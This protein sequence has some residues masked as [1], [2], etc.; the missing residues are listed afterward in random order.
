MSTELPVHRIYTSPGHLLSY[1]MAS[2]G[3]S[4]WSHV[5]NS[6]CPSL[7]IGMH[8]DCWS[9]LVMG[10]HMWHRLNPLSLLKLSG[11]SHTSMASFT[12]QSMYP[13]A[14]PSL[15]VSL[16][17]VWWAVSIILCHCWLFLLLELDV[18]H[19]LF[20]SG[21]DGSTSLPYIDFNTFTGTAE[22]AS[23]L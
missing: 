13:I 10:R 6:A 7:P 17:S 15:E 1:W 20:L 4:G 19:V 18:P 8:V 11:Y 23:N 3:A 16:K 22:D 2:R 5:P 12:R 21:L 14:F 9:I